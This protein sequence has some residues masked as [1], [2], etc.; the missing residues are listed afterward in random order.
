MDLENKEEIVVEE[1]TV[2]TAEVVATEETT[3][4]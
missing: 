4:E 1:A 2:E 3:E